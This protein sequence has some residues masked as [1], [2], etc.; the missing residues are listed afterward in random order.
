[1]RS[2]RRLQPGAKRF[3]A[4]LLQSF[5]EKFEIPNFK[6]LPLRSAPLSYSRSGFLP[7]A[8][9]R[10]LTR[11]PVA[12]ERH[13]V[14]AVA[15]ECWPRQSP[16]SSTSPSLPAPRGT[17]WRV[18]PFVDLVLV[19]RRRLLYCRCRRHCRCN[20]RRRRCCRRNRCRR[21]HCR[22]HRRRRRRGISLPSFPPRLPR[23]GGTCATVVPPSSKNF[24][25]FI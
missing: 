23:P 14:L 21:R 20:Y 22:R 24:I 5:L 3:C 4:L 12:A 11:L 7:S 13:H 15:S 1:M 19:G 9:V 16:S 2:G 17:P 10:P 25:L 8:V 6:S 18:T